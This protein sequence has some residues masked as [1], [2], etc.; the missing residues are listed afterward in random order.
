MKRFALC[1]VFCVLLAV[2][3]ALANDTVDWGQLGP[4]GARC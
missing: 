4:S 1:V 3:G 2:S